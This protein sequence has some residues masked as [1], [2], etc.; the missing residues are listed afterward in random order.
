MDAETARRH[1][2]PLHALTSRKISELGYPVQFPTVLV[3]AESVIP[4][5]DSPLRIIPFR[6]AEAAR[7]PRTEDTVIEM[8]HIDSIGA[9]ALLDRN[10]VRMDTTYL[11]RRILEERLERRATFVRFSE[12]I[13]ALPRV[14][15]SLSADA[16]ARKLRKNPAGSGFR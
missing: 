14:G 7:D 10:R 3:A 2:V 8:L 12:V 13:P 1:R 11:L 15:E 5:V 16:L 9:R 6:S 4:L